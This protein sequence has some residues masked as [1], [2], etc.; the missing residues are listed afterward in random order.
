MTTKTHVLFSI[1]MSVVVVVAVVWGI[2][3]AGS[4]L[5]SPVATFRPTTT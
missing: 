2:A 5:A 4:A 1:V 3:L